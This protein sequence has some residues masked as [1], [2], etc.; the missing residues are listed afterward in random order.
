MVHGKQ[1]LRKLYDTSFKYRI[2]TYKN[3]MRKL[4]LTAI[5]VETAVK[6]LK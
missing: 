1:Q 5:I 2:T 4:N 6:M 3:T